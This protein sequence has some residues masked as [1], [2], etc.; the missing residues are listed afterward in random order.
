M[1]SIVY[2]IKKRNGMCEGDG[3]N[4]TNEGMH[5]S[6][7]RCDLGVAVARAW[8]CGVGGYQSETR[9]LS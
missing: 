4:E 2:D 1:R 3:A 5:L 6:S 8:S 7:T 9:L